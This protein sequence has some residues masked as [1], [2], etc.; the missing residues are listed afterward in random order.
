MRKHIC[1]QANISLKDY[2][3]DV[4]LGKTDLEQLA[5]QARHL[6]AHASHQQ[7]SWIECVETFLAENIVSIHGQ[8]VDASGCCICHSH[9]SWILSSLPVPSL[10]PE[11]MHKR[12]DLTQDKSSWEW[13]NNSWEWWN[14][15]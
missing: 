9:A 14:D 13:W 6:L 5:K 12:K 8:E 3:H 10:S 15:S 2:M 11:K 1:R 7:V 4:K